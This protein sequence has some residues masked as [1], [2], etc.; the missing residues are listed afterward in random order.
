MERTW[1][2]ILICFIGGI[3]FH[4]LFYG[5]GIGISYPLYVMYLYLIF[6][7]KVPSKGKKQTVFDLLLFLSA[8]LL[9]ASF[10]L[11]SHIILLLLNFTIVPILLFIHM[12]HS[13]RWEMEKWSNRL[14]IKSMFLT[15]FET[16]QQ[17]FKLL[18]FGEQIGKGVM[19]EKNYQIAKKIVIGFVL[20]I[21]LLW[22]ILYLLMSSDQQFKSLLSLFPTWLQQ[23]NIGSILFQAFIIGF[24]TLWLFAY[25]I[26]LAKPLVMNQ[27]PIESQAVKMDI[28]IV[29]TI[30]SML[31]IVYFLYTVVQFSYFFSGDPSSGSLGYTY[32]EYARRGFTELTIVSLINLGLL[33]LFTHGSHF[34]KV[35]LPKV[36]KL[37]LSVLV[38]FTFVMLS[39]AYYRLSL[40]EQAYG[41]T[42]SRVYAHAFM[43]LLCFMLILAMFKVVKERFK[44]LRAM[45]IVTLV[46]YVTL[47][48]LNIDQLIVSQNMNRYEATGK[49][50]VNY[51]STLSYDAIP[52]LL[53]QD[54]EK[55]HKFLKGKVVEVNQG[56]KE[57]QSFNFSKAKAK[58][59]LNE[60]K[61][62]E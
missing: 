48:Y 34:Q 47:N 31:N 7:I 3:L 4:Y 17:F 1:K 51:L 40:Y 25:F 22:T 45:F 54:H 59:L 16:V 58:R 56:P 14:F 44:L 42:Y 53:E 50:D 20:S 8:C 29:S 39:S 37:L 19:H 6:Y 24:I 46:A 23:A 60:W 43:I 36:M 33:F 52:A 62:S 35:M 49:L 26:T 18:H 2:N 28:V 41:Y 15:F 12:V 38:I 32:A 57:W 10:T 5:K 9:A 13:R 11:S 27:D 61:E 30:L 55:F 21:P